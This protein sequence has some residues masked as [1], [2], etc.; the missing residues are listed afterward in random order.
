MKRSK[1]TEEQIIAVL[2]E[3]VTRWCDRNLLRE[4]CDMSARYGER[5][6]RSPRDFHLFQVREGVR[7]LF[8][9]LVS[10]G[11]IDIDFGAK[12]KLA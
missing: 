12:I 1:F 6:L 7:M 8:V 3:Q 9:R 2:R 5:S 11:Q 4:W 10:G